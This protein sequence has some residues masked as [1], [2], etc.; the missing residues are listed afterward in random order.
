MI[1]IV[2]YFAVRKQSGKEAR[3]SMKMENFSLSAFFSTRSLAL[4]RDGNLKQ[5]KTRETAERSE[6]EENILL[7]EKLFTE[8]I[9]VIEH[10]T[11]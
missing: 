9:L 3:E 5:N 7:M 11:K 8:N 10:D 6:D 1:L 4:F 2:F